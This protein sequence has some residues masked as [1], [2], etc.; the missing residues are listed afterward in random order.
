MFRNSFWL[1]E[2]RQHLSKFLARVTKA[3]KVKTLFVDVH[4]N[5]VF[6]QAEPTKPSNMLRRAKFVWNLLS[7]R[8]INW[9][10]LGQTNDWCSIIPYI[11]QRLFKTLLL[12]LAFFN[13]IKGK[14]YEKYFHKIYDFICQKIVRA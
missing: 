9:I 12:L 2:S 5:D 10:V 4:F 11:I 6:F 14:K 13:I 3:F 7:L 8:K 1:S